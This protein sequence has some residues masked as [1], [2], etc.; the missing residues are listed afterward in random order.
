AAHHMSFETGR[1]YT[2]NAVGV[3]EGN[4]SNLGIASPGGAE[5]SWSDHKATKNIGHDTVPPE[6]TVLGAT[7]EEGV[8]AVLGGDIDAESAF[9]VEFVK[10]FKSNKRTTTTTAPGEDKRK[11]CA[12]PK[13]VIIR[14]LPKVV[15]STVQT[16]QTSGT[17]A[18]LVDLNGVLVH[19]FRPH[20]K[21]QPPDLDSNDHSIVK[22]QYSTTYVHKDAARF[23]AW[24][25]QI[26]DVY[27]WSSMMLCN[28]EQ[29]LKCCLPVAVKCLRGWLGQECCEVAS[30]EFPRGK[31]VFFK[32][33]SVFFERHSGKY[34]EGNTLAIDDSWYK[35][36]HNRTGTCHI[37]KREEGCSYGRQIVSVVGTMGGY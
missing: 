2:E 36:M 26:A 14:E 28:L 29:K 27:I 1:G 8:E 30:F 32:P 33:L 9:L 25:S 16:N 34:H 4:V 13:E 37:A 17:L 21:E 35:H 18:L 22:E 7:S 19:T 31:P 15:P 10:W 24:A 23:L 12:H 20:L 3:K 5:K 6:S 11:P